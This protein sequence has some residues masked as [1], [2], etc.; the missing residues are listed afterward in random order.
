MILLLTYV[1][2]CIHYDCVVY[3]I[4][5]WWVCIVCIIDEEEWLLIEM[6]HCD[7]DNCDAVMED[8]GITLLCVIV[9]YYI[10]VIW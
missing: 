5:L 8:I 9:Y 6:Y 3:D 2:V 1:C 4:I 10:I 7:N